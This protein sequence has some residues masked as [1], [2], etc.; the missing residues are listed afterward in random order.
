MPGCEL[1]NLQRA[2]FRFA[3]YSDYDDLVKKPSLSERRRRSWLA[4][5]LEQSSLS[6]EAIAGRLFR[7][8][9]I[10]LA[11][12]LAPSRCQRGSE[13]RQKNRRWSP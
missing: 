12:I 8:T 2:R 13:G 5:G 4:V 10:R 11:K 1:L 9:R 3:G 6:S 7:L